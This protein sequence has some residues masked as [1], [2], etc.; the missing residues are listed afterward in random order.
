MRHTAL[1]LSSVLAFA[2]S[3]HA[4]DEELAVALKRT[5]KA[6]K[7]LDLLAAD[8]VLAEQALGEGMRVVPLGKSKLPTLT[9]YDTADGALGKQAASIR[10]REAGDR[11]TIQFKPKANIQGISQRIEV[12]IVL[13]ADEAGKTAALEK[14]LQHAPLQV[15][16][17]TGGQRIRYAIEKDGQRV[18]QV[19]LEN[20]FIHA[21]NGKAG[22]GHLQYV[23]AG[24]Q[25]AKLVQHLGVNQP[26]SKIK[27][28]AKLIKARR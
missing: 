11:M 20:N 25:G 27:S 14:F 8:P 23:G 4:A 13:K 17:T 5:G 1:V 15:S 7:R 21:R 22:F 26:A 19:E 3:A 28:A 9:H 16:G 18:G 6:K 24:E 12:P 10:V 2:G